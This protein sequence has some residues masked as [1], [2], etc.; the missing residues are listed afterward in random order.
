MYKSKNAYEKNTLSRKCC[1]T[2]GNN[3][4]VGIPHYAD[5]RCAKCQYVKKTQ[6]LLFNCYIVIPKN[7]DKTRS[8]NRLI[9]IIIT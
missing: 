3:R 1:M 9:K 2:H 6:I 8:L 4:K 5:D 7:K